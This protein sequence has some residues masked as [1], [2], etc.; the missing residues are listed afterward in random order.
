[1]VRSYRD[2]SE[3]Y[4][5]EAVRLGMTDPA[6]V[7]L[8]KPW[9]R[10]EKQS[11]IDKLNS[12]L[13]SVQKEHK[14]EKTRLKR[15]G[16]KARQ[17]QEGVPILRDV[18][19][20]LKQ[21]VEELGAL[22]QRV[23]GG[24]GTKSADTMVREAQER[25]EAY[26]LADTADKVPDFLQRGVRGAVRSVALAVPG[27]LVAGPYGAIG[28]PSLAVGNRAITEARDA[29]LI[30]GQLHEYVG[31]QA[32]LEALFASVFQVAG[33]GG[34]ESIFRRGITRAGWKGALKQ[35]ARATGWEIPEEMLTEYSQALSDKFYG[36]DPTE[37]SLEQAGRIFI[38]TLTQ[39]TLATGAISSVSSVANQEAIKNREKYA[40]S[41]GRQHGLG[42]EA[43]LR[44]M[45][46]AARGKNFNEALGKELLE[47]RAL[48]KIGLAEWIVESPENLE[49][50]RELAEHTSPFRFETFN[51]FWFS[52]SP[53]RWRFPSYF[54]FRSWFW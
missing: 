15:V 44:A 46:K 35:G 26:A 52:R 19:A 25:E 41:L 5:K 17:I 45:D 20:G 21:G 34:L 14:E 40:K 22:L 4:V 49:A 1:M 47:E 18:P 2:P 32:G 39:T 6:V 8:G 27:G 42:E 29:G 16:L 53:G 28:L 31:I 10:E 36:I 23:A 13:P 33:K 12:L 51:L 54:G 48:T 9:T 11:F 38:D 24:P 3:S 7:V 43:S 30:G 37:W 50:A